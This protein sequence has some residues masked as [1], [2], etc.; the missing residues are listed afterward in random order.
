VDIP[1]P[2]VYEAST[3]SALDASGIPVLVQGRQASSIHNLR[4][5]L[6]EYGDPAKFPDGEKQLVTDGGPG[7][8]ISSCTVQ[9]RCDREQ[10]MGW[11][12][13]VLMACS[14]FPGEDRADILKFSP[15]IHRIELAVDQGFVFEADMP[16]D[17]PTTVEPPPVVEIALRVPKEDRAISAAARNVEVRCAR[18]NVSL[19][20]FKGLATTSTGDIALRPSPLSLGTELSRRIEEADRVKKLDAVK[21]NCHS[22]VPFAYVIFIIDEARHH[23]PIPIQFSGISGNLMKEMVEG[24]HK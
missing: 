6:M 5:L 21:L 20:T 16:V 19:G 23:R 4:E 3:G 18:E 1:I 15:H 24:W 8:P 2:S 11:I 13:V 22:R 14:M 9:I 10:D 17:L 7:R 12:A